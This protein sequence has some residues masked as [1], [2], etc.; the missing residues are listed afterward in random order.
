MS[1]E[2]ANLTQEQKARF[3]EILV[4]W[5]AASNADTVK[6]F[7]HLVNQDVTHYHVGGKYA[8]FDIGGSGAFMVEIE[9]GTVYGIKGYGKINKA[10]NS[11]NIY[12]PGFNGSVLVRDRFRYGRFVNNADGSVKSMGYVAADE[13]FLD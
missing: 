5:Q 6:R 10:K 13:R 11:G 1:F 4:Q 3:D 9:T 8:R 12:D 7:G 2:T